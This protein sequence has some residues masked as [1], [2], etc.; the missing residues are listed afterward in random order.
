MKV[1]TINSID[2]DGYRC[3][4]TIEVNGEYRL[5][6]CDGE[7]EDNTLDR[8]FNDVYSIS[9]LMQ[10]AFLAGKNGETLELEDVDVD[11]CEW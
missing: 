2:D 5:E 11:W 1:K 6:F 8:G 4:I 7:P 3:F 10:E 9:S